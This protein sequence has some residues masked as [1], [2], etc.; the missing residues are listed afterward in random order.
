MTSARTVARNAV[1]NFGGQAIPLVVGA[2]TIPFTMRWLGP[3]RFGVLALVWVLVGY[4]NVFDLGLGRATT[5]FV[6]AA[7]GRG[8]RD[9]SSLAGTALASQVILGF[10]GGLIML[11]GAPVLV[12]HV[13]NLPPGIAGEAKASF[14]LL[15]FAAPVVLVSTSLRGILEAAQR[16]DLVNAVR[17]PSGSMHF[18][19]PL[20][21]AA[22]NWSLPRIVLSILVLQATGMVCQ[23]LLCVRVLP[24]LRRPRVD[25]RIFRRL[26]GFGGW[27][28]VSG[29]VGPILVYVDRF[30]IAAVLS[31]AAVGYYTGP[32]ELVTRLSII[33]TSLVVAL[34]PVFSARHDAP[35]HLEALAARSLRTLLVVMGAVVIATVALGGDFVRL[36]LGAEVARIVTVPFKILAVGVLVNALALVP[37]A[38]LQAIGRPDITGKIH[39]IEL[40]IHLLF[41]WVLVGAFGLV[42][43]ALAWSI[44]AAI[45]AVLLFVAAARYGPLGFRSLFAQGAPSLA[46]WIAVGGIMAFGSAALPSLPLRAAALAVVLAGVATKM[47][48][49][50][51]NDLHARVSV[52]SSQP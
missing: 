7:L 39:L 37:Y 12:D 40:P 44:R 34:F 22:A 27:V 29:L 42:G 24:T 51:W 43:A 38:L 48:G 5:R 1:L 50:G 8:Q 15:A 11:L 47:L 10:V 49:S 18:L 17:V 35:S 41:V 13:L 14:T 21:G 30:V 52:G 33:P 2:V 9:V 25:L 45:D 23:Y 46:G 31:V 6:A 28:A 36:W 16:F 4:L 3:S 20:I 32:Y 19:L 26:A